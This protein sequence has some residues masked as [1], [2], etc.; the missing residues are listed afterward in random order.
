MATAKRADRPEKNPHTSGRAAHY[1][2]EITKATK[3]QTTKRPS[4]KLKASLAANLRKSH[5][6]GTKGAQAPKKT[7]EQRKTTLRQ[8]L[9]NISTGI[10]KR[11]S[12]KR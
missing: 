11:G 5:D 4:G 1:A 6:K 3:K 2:R 8:H 7:A 9:R 10:K 12:G